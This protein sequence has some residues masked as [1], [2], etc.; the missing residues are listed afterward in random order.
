V[1]TLSEWQLA[2][3]FRSKSST[4]DAAVQ[5]KQNESCAEKTEQRLA[6]IGRSRLGNRSPYSP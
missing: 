6:R 2:Q 5:K 1:R 4:G 3:F